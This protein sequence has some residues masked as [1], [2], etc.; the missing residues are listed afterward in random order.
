[1]C[2]SIGTK[3]SLMNEAVSSS[4]YD[5]ASSRAHAPQGG[6]ALKS[7]STGFFAVLA[8]ASAASASFI[9]FTFMVLVPPRDLFG[10][11]A[12]E[13]LLVRQCVSPRAVNCAVAMFWW[14]VERVK[15]Q[16]LSIGSIDDVVFCAGGDDNRGAVG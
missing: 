4:L 13:V 14:R 15:F 11:C 8:S 2:A 9:Q 7:T 16:L 1:M 12:V 6:A 3:L 10:G 5:S